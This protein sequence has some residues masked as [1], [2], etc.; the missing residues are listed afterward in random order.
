MDDQNQQAQIA[1]YQIDGKPTAVQVSYRGNTYWVSPEGMI[2]Y[3]GVSISAISKYLATM[4]TADNPIISKKETVWN[5]GVRSVRHTVTLPLSDF[6]N[7]AQKS[8]A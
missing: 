3:F 4:G 1:V 6:K 8:D 5:E 7:L 2:D